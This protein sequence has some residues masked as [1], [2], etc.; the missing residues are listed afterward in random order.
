VSHT[1]RP[2]MLLLVLPTPALMTVGG[3]IHEGL[4]RST[5]N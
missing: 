5:S 1:V 4:R 2:L 3:A